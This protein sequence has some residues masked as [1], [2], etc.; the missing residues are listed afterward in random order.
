M[1]FLFKLFLTFVTLTIS[2]MVSISKN[3]VFK[4]K[5]VLNIESKPKWI[6]SLILSNLKEG[7]KYQ[8]LVI[9][10][11]FLDLC[12]RRKVCPPEILSLARRV[13]RQGTN[14]DSEK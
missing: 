1:L 3:T 5:Q 13:G 14:G 7:L 6:E 9:Q 8:K 10:K 11:D 2:I 12:A 4:I